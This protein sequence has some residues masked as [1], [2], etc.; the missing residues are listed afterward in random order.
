MFSE[1]IKKHIWYY[2]SLIVLQAMGLWLMLLLSF[3]KQ[4]QIR[5]LFLTTGAY[6]FWALLHQQLHHSLHPKI[7]MEYIFVGG[8][9]LAIS[10]LVFH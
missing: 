3:D 2:S 5:A 9:G 1:R 4:L 7:V 6:L 10:L 8:I